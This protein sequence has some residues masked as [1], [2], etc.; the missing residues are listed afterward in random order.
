MSRLYDA[1][2]Q[3]GGRRPAPG[4]L[5]LVQAFANSF[6][7]LEHQRGTDLFETPAG[8]AAWL[9]VRGLGAGAVSAAELRRA[10]AVREGIRA[11]LRAHN[12]MPRDTTALAALREA[13][14]GLTVAFRVDPE[15][16]TEPVPA[17]PGVAG[18]LGLVLAIVHEARV[19]GTWSRL[20]ACPGS[21]C[22]W[23]FYD[24]STSRTSTWCSMRV[25][26]GREKARA[27]RRRVRALEAASS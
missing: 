3:S 19:Q 27:Y 13:A 12:G 4:R 9:A 23:A 20:K 11:S 25:C 6:Y 16:R 2:P 10:V 14:D 17:G 22:G 8:L 18:A 7:D 5:A 24:H 21:D 15:G 26:G 1:G